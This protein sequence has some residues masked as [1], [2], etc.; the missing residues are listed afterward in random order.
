MSLTRAGDLCSCLIPPDHRARWMDDCHDT[1]GE[2]SAMKV[3]T[4]IPGSLG[5]RNK[6]DAGIGDAFPWITMV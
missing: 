4:H 5:N 1:P 2:R 3:G 6:A